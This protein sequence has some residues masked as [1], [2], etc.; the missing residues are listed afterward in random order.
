MLDDI[1]KYFFGRRCN[2]ENIFQAVAAESIARLSMLSKPLFPIFG[3][4]VSQSELENSIDLRL[5]I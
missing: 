3:R 1:H 4:V 2:I 5:R